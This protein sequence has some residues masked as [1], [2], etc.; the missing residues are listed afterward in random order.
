[1]KPFWKAFN[2]HGLATGLLA[3]MTATLIPSCSNSMFE[4]DP[5]PAVEVTESSESIV[6]FATIGEFE[7]MTAADIPG[8]YAGNEL[9][10]LQY[11]CVDTI[12]LRALRFNVTAQ[13]SDAY[14]KSKE[15][16]FTADVGPELVS[17]EYYP[18]GEMQEAHHNLV[19]AYYPKVERYRNYSDGSRIGPDLFY[20]NGHF[21]DLSKAHQVHLNSTLSPNSEVMSWNDFLIEEFFNDSGEINPE[22]MYYEN[23]WY[24]THYKAQT[25]INVN[26]T[27][28]DVNGKKYSGED[29]LPI[30]PDEFYDGWY[31][32]YKARFES[33]KTDFYGVNEY[34]INRYTLSRGI[35]ASDDELEI[36]NLCKDVKDVSPKAFP[37]DSHNL[38]PGFYFG[39]DRDL[40]A[41]SRLTY[42]TIYDLNQPEEGVIRGLGRW[43]SL[44]FY[45]QYLVIDGR[46]IHF[47]DIVNY[48]YLGRDVMVTHTPNGYSMHLE[49][50][51][52]VFGYNF[53]L[54]DDIEIIKV[55]GPQILIDES[56]YGKI[57]EN[58]NEELDQLNGQASKI[59]SNDEQSA[60]LPRNDGNRM[61]IDR[62]LPQSIRSVYKTRTINL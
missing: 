58:D 62:T 5:A 20:D 51:H 53:K 21:V 7:S 38:Q 30:K 23:G 33:F 41:P 40:E 9:K 18:G 43:I 25:E 50:N 16:R 49:E 34:G 35:G 42:Y 60:G 2:L 11:E 45:L 3:V 47:N 59:R 39:R 10:S 46:I 28:I 4:P 26:Y 12:E 57:E 8:D 24:C 36:M 1:M 17:V 54:I 15:V 6:K 37:S 44:S 14:G 31:D 55:N 52:S 32:I 56:E 19:T 48:N 13:L 22:Y 27:K 29:L 61:K